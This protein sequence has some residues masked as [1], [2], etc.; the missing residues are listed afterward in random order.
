MTGFH[1]DYQIDYFEA[2]TLQLTE[3]K[4]EEQRTNISVS[5]IVHPKHKRT[6]RSQGKRQKHDECLPS[7]S[8]Y[9]GNEASQDLQK[10]GRL[11]EASE[12]SDA[13]SSLMENMVI[14][15]GIIT[16]RRRGI[17]SPAAN[18]KTTIPFLL[19]GS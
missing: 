10:I 16:K 3:M 15:W 7:L 5:N 13:Q 8:T 6:L 2:M 4:P 18:T 17:R 19:S 9:T 1:S 11:I 14:D 12:R